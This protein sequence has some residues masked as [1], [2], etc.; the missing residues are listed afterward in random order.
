M[1][2]ENKNSIPAE[3]VPEIAK[4]LM[5]L[6]GK[7]PEIAVTLRNIGIPIRIAE[8]ALRKTGFLS[9]VTDAEPNALSVS[10]KP[11]DGENHPRVGIIN[12]QEKPKAS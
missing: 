7:G 11:Y 2:H 4:T 6:G 9:V 5:A 10:L 12:W 1:S 8:E 3:H